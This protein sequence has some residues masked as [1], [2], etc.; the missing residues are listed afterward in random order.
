MEDS[1]NRVGAQLFPSLSDKLMLQK[2]T[3]TVFYEAKRVGNC[4]LLVA[5]S[6]CC[7]ATAVSLVRADRPYTGPIPAAA[8]VADVAAYL[9][10]SM[11]ERLFPYTLGSP[12]SRLVVS[13]SSLPTRGLYQPR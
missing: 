10:S 2:E 1:R 7:L 3:A 5:V 8:I 4:A 12:A 11:T 13:H 6:S 9:E